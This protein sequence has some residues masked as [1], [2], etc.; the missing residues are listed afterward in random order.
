MFIFTP[1]VL[2]I[3]VSG[4]SPTVQ[5]ISELPKYLGQSLSVVNNLWFVICRGDHEW[6]SLDYLI[7]LCFSAAKDKRTDGMLSITASGHLCVE[8]KML[9]DTSPCTIKSKAFSS[10]V[11]LSKASFSPP[12]HTPPGL[13]PS[14]IHSFVVS[15][16]EKKLVRGIWH[17]GTGVLDGERRVSAWFSY[18]IK[19]LNSAWLSI[20]WWWW[21]SL[22]AGLKRSSRRLGRLFMVPVSVISLWQTTRK[23]GLKQRWKDWRK[24]RKCVFCQ[25]AHTSSEGEGEEMKSWEI[26]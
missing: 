20:A 18:G 5:S 4:S 1:D 17:N 24:E 19:E 14:L 8:P 7:T 15:K 6:F 26:A 23:E 21:I 25:T 9:S 12:A 3:L 2:L 13:F 11:C 10:E 22:M 16:E